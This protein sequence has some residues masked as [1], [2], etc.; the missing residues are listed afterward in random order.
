MIYKVQIANLTLINRMY[1]KDAAGYIS[2]KLNE[3]K[4]FDDTVNK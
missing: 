2:S 4:A 3:G 1:S